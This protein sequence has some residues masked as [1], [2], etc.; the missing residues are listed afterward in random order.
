M[1]ERLLCKENFRQVAG[2]AIIVVLAALW[3]LFSSGI[4]SSGKIVKGVVLSAGPYSTSGV[5]GATQQIASVRL[6][7][8]R[9]VQ[10]L[11]LQDDHIQPGTP[12]TLREESLSCNPTAY[13]IVDHN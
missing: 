8:G 9:V 6:S 4:L 2:A 12:V 7:D 3:G 1:L 13:E 5:C 11:V 10:A